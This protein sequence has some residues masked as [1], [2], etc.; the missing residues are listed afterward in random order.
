MSMRLVLLLSL[1]MPFAN[2]SADYSAEQAVRAADAR[3]WQ[4]FNGCD[5]DAMGGL[6]TADVEF[7]HDKTGLT[8]GRQAVLDSLRNG[9]CANALI[10]AQVGRVVIAMSRID[11]D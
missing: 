3:Y 6:L 8:V 1:F 10:Q 4:A 7:Y 11:F 9:P 2:A 5:F